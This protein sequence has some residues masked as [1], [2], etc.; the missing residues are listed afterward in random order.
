MENAVKLAEKHAEEKYNVDI[1]LEFADCGDSA[2]KTKSA[3]LELVNKGVDVVIGAYSSTQAISA[4]ETAN[5]TS[6]L[7]IATVAST[8]RIEKMVLEGNRYVF[9]NA[10]NTT[11]WGE[12]A[13][14]FLKMSN[15]DGYYFQGYQPLSTFNQGM[16]EVIKRKT[17]T[18]PKEV[19]FYNPSADP[20][21]VSNKAIEAVE[22]VGNRDVLILGDPG[23]LAVSYLKEYRQNGGRGIIYSVGGVLAL[24]QT[25]QSL[26]EIANYTAFQSAS[27]EN[28]RTTEFTEKYFSDYRK[29]YGEN[30]N[31][32]AG[33]LTYDAVLILAQAVEKSGK[34]TDN[35]IKELEQGEFEGACGIYKFNSAHQAMWGSEE[36]KGKIAEWVG[37]IIVLYPESAKESDIVWQQ[38]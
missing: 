29:E 32:Y 34:S 20:K 23:P 11:Y 35:L 26:G 15:A 22:K 7:Y 5:Q 3:F 8:E 28:I 30:A 19:S 25:L 36:L 18:E 6:K 10:Y 31:N 21:D 4:G 16:L 1:E 38:T 12:L 14:I 13:G 17:G 2:E 33:V 27:L 24:P 9:R 37:K